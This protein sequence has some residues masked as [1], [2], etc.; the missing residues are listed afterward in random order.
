VASGSD[1]LIDADE[2]AGRA[3]PPVTRLLPT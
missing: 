1:P 2:A 3:E